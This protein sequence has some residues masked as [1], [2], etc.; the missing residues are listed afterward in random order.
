MRLA[1]QHAAGQRAGMMAAEEGVRVRGRQQQPALVLARPRIPRGGRIRPYDHYRF[2]KGTVA[3]RWPCLADLLGGA[4]AQ[5][6]GGGP[7]GRADGLLHHEADLADAV[8]QTDGGVVSDHVVALAHVPGFRVASRIPN[9]AKRRLHSFGAA[10]TWLALQSFIARTVDTKPIVA[11]RDEAL[12][13]AAS[14][15]TGR[16]APR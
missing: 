6:P 3:S 10:S 12:R 7:G 1:V 16:S 8:H 13:L 14:V 4:A 11:Y 2:A 5:Q 9:L 15:H